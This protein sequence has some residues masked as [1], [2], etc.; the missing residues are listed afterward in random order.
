MPDID[1]EAIPAIKQLKLTAVT[2]LEIIKESR[3]EMQSIIQ[4]LQN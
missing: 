1:W 2:A 4:A 3:Q